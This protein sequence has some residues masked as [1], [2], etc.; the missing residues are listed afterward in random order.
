M[1]YD[2]FSFFNELDLLEIRLNTLDKVVDRFVISESHYTHT[3]QPKPLYYKEN[4]SRF[5]KFKGKVIHVVSPDPVDPA[6]AG[7]DI[8]CS[9]LCEN[10]QRNATIQA[11]ESKLEDDDVL[12]VSDIDEIPNPSAVV[13]AIKLNR[14][15]RLRQKFYCYYLNY[16]CCTTPYWTTGSVVL[17]YR[18]FRNPATYKTT[19]DGMAFNSIENS[20]PSATKVRALR[21]IKMMGDGG[22]HFSY[23]GGIEKILTKIDSIVEGRS[24]TLKDKA[25]INNCI[26]S[27]NDIYDRGEW[28]FAEKPDST[29]PTKS[30]DFPSLFF[31]TDNAYL[32]AVR[33]KRLLAYLKWLVRPI[34]WK[35]IPLGLAT[36]LS[37]RFSRI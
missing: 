16:R 12:I 2:C 18:D 10:R 36:R 37:K 34:A 19:I 24:A 28:F 13:R 25:S 27:G 31:P 30:K 4:E 20:R 32:R 7:Q 3:G 23:I 29:F 5:A 35:L 6:K 9:W 14:P 17:R 1:I 15:A 26:L 21:G 22:W 8:S 33:F 11:I